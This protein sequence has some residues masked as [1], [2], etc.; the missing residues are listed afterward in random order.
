MASI[1]LKPLER[2]VVVVTGASSGIGL[3][4]AI[5]AV[6]TDVARRD[7]LEHLAQVAIARFGRIDTVCTILPPIGPIGAAEITRRAC[8]ASCRVPSRVCGIA[9]RPGTAGRGPGAT[10]AAS[11]RLPGGRPLRRT[12]QCPPGV[13]SSPRR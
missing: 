9:P 3:A 5:A 11:M 4:T 12:R 2:Q 7:D 13:S 1:G 8:A 10:A 6:E